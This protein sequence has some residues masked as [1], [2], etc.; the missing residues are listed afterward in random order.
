ALPAVRAAAAG[1]APLARAR[2]ERTFHP[3]VVTKQLLD[4]YAGMARR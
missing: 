3:D 4:V 1:V 2:Y